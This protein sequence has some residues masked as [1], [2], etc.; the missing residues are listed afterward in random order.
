MVRHAPRAALLRRYGID[1]TAFRPLDQGLLNHSFAADTADGPLFLKQYLEQRPATIRFQHRVTADLR[2]AGLPVVAPLG[3][4]TGRTLNRSGSLLFALFPW[5]E[6]SHRFGQDLTLPQCRELGRTLG[7]VHRVLAEVLGPVPQPLFQHSARVDDALATADRLLVASRARAAREGID[8]LAEYRLLERRELLSR[9]AHRRPRMDAVG[10][11]GYVHGDFHSL[12][13]FHDASGRVSAVVDWD[14][15]GI[16]PRAE[17]LVR[18]ALIIFVDP[19]DG[20]LDLDRAHEYVH[21]YLEV[22]PRAAA[23]L[24]LAVHRVWWE[25]LTDFW[26]LI[27]RYERDDPRPGALFPASSALIVWWTHDYDKV[28]HALSA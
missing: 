18:S 25:R 8:E 7:W 19:K 4:L 21:G 9:Y 11:V 20:T 10:D 3:D 17:E 16:G 24:A 26:M 23:D 13:V 5:V 12:N 6:G 27:W 22:R 15:L 2:A 28:L 1:A 14:R